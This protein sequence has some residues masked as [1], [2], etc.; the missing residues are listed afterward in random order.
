MGTRDLVLLSEHGQN[1]KTERMWTAT[2][3]VISVEQR[4]DPPVGKENPLAQFCLSELAQIEMSN[5]LGL[6]KLVADG[7]QQIFTFQ[8]LP[9]SFSAVGR[10]S[11]PQCIKS[12][13]P[14][15]CITMREIL[16]AIE[17]PAKHGLRF[18]EKSNLK[19]KVSNLDKRGRCTEQ[20]PQ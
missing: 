18:P 5:D 8:L 11:F 12:H 4:V 20:E 6:V 1:P 9:N 15:F 10:S 14:A 19:F 3:S 13:S 2:L 17:L 7:A 16:T